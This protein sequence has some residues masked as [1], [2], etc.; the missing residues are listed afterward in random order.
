MV[1]MRKD[2]SLN[3]QGNLTFASHL[4]V[5]WYIQSNFA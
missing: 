1:I 2:K 3:Y 4:D 5:I